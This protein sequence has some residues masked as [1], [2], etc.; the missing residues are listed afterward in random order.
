MIVN[1]VP[2]SLV[3]N[4]EDVSTGRSRSVVNNRPVGSGNEWR[5]D[6]TSDVYTVVKLRL[7]GNRMPAGTV[8]ATSVDRVRFRPRVKQTH[9]YT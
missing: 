1:R 2:V 4:D 5:S 7:T 6:W 3:A 8:G 9:R